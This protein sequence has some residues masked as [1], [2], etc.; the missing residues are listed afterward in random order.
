M[1]RGL[2]HLSKILVQLEDRSGTE[3]FRADGHLFLESW[4]HHPLAVWPLDQRLHSWRPL[5]PLLSN[6]HEI[7]SC[8]A[9]SND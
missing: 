8:L 7:I 9:G 2:S 5:L 4:L 6:G 3:R 1:S